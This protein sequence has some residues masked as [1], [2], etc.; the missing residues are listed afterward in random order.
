MRT[1]RIISIAVVA[2][3][4]IVATAVVIL[5]DQPQASFNPDH[6]LKGTAPTITISLDKSISDKIESVSI[7][8]GDPVK[9][10][11]PEGKVS[12]LLP[13]LDIVGRAYVSVLDKDNKPLAVGQLT[14]VEPAEQPLISFAVLLLVY[15][16]LIFALPLICTIYDIYKSY[17][18]RAT[19]LGKLQSH[20]STDEI[21]ALLVDMDQGPTGLTGLTR[22]IV[23]V[24]LILVLAV[25]VFHLVVFAPRVPDIAEKLLMLLAGTL[26]AI[27]GFYFGSKATAEAAQ[28]PPSDAVKA[29]SAVAPK[30]L[31]FDP[32]LSAANT[33]I[34]VI[35][36]G[37]GQ[38]KGTVTVG[39]KPSAV[40]DWKD[41]QIEV[42][43]P[44]DVSGDVSIVVTNDK[45]KPSD[46][47]LFKIAPLSGEVKTGSAVVP[48]ISKVDS[49]SDAAKT[50]IN[51]FG[52]GFGSRQGKGTVKFGGKP[53]EVG[54]WKDTQIEV[55]IP[56]DVTGD[57]SIVVTSDEGMPS[58]PFSFKIT[59]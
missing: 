57:V 29:G 16:L 8:G 44:A 10:Q 28:K 1:G 20:L 32:E 23:A 45:G 27:T 53:A 30:I 35:G 24:T 39:G 6:I 26:T 40:G 17:K 19:V 56:A 42:T 48:K 25:A 3:V 54:N 31:K 22:G 9:V 47:K 12:V 41:T 33:Q 15:L 14:Y 55:T 4:V 5:A 49:G 52:E 46:P 13:K 59:T 43:V 21:K 11:K 36:E 50:Q 18:E 2:V 51:V 37:F 34:K 38:G 7:G 58:E